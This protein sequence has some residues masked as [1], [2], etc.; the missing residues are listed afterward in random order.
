M[1]NVVHEGLQLSQVSEAVLLITDLCALAFHR[2][3]LKPI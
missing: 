3:A 1:V 2:T